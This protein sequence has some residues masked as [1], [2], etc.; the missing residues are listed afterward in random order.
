M[1]YKVCNIEGFEG[2][3]HIFSNGDIYSVRKR[4]LVKTHTNGH[5][6]Y[7]YVCLTGHNKQQLRTGI[8]R[9]IAHHWIS[10]QPA[11][12]IAL[13]RY[14]VNHI[15]TNAMNNNYLNLEWVTHHDNMDKAHDL[16]GVWCKGRK[17]GFKHTISTKKL[18]SYKK[19]TKVMLFNDNEQVIKDSI[20][21]AANYLSVSRRTIERYN[22]TYKTIKGFKIKSLYIILY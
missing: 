22:N 11:N 7:Q 8:H 4:K 10:P 9:I 21:D 3:Y 12:H 13:G 6:N 19:K 5:Y 16:K 20:Q 17:A 15:D 1:D 14:E 2:L 18:M